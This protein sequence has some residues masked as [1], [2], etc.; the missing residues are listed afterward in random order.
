MI[1][2]LPL[3]SLLCFRPHTQQDAVGAEA[4]GLQVVDTVGTDAENNTGDAYADVDAVPAKRRRISSSERLAVRFFKELEALLGC[5]T[6]ETLR[7]LR[8]TEVAVFL[9]SN[10]LRPKEIFSFALH[11]DFSDSYH[12]HDPTA[13]ETQKVIGNAARRVIREC[14]P[15][16]ASCAPP[17]SSSMKVFIMVKVPS[18]SLSGGTKTNGGEIPQPPPGF[19]PKR[20]FVPS[21]RQTKVKVDFNVVVKRDN[22][23]VGGS[24]QLC[25]DCGG[26]SGKNDA[27]VNRLRGGGKIQES[28]DGQGEDAGA[29]REREADLESRVVIESIWYQCSASVKGLKGAWT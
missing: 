29:T 6:P 19:I 2:I 27:G 26:G 15:A 11:D 5:L 14:L 4:M 23:G 1:R 25:G 12:P 10:P 22:G 20:G 17:T 24:A 18:G 21:L 13:N 3:S 8:P 28:G 9:G 16:V 7:L